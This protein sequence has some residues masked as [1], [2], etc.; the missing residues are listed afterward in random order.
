MTNDDNIS[1]W[2]CTYFRWRFGSGRW[3]WKINAYAD[4]AIASWP[5]ML[6]H[7]CSSTRYHLFGHFV[8][9]LVFRSKSSNSN[10]YIIYPLSFIVPMPMVCIT[11]CS[12]PS[13]WLIKMVSLL[14]RKA[15][16]CWPL[17]KASE[18]FWKTLQRLV[19]TGRSCKAQS[20]GWRYCVGMR[21]GLMFA[22]TTMII[23]N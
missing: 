3:S 16:H 18:A 10:C 6:K 23:R 13:Q 15:V 19:M 17:N 5:D 8:W 12:S 7:R 22:G 14:D 1:V 2:C 21:M 9:V 20:I 11:D 4:V